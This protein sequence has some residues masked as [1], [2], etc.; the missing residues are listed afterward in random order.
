MAE[1]CLAH[2]GVKGMRWGVRRY[3]NEDGTLTPAGKRRYDKV[4]KKHGK[5]YTAKQVSNL[6]KVR[7]SNFAAAAVGSIM[8]GTGA[9][10]RVT[11]GRS[12]ANDVLRAVGGGMT[13]GGLAGG[14]VQQGRLRAD[15]ILRSGLREEKRDG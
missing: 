13:I 3:E 7:N 1:H 15:N 2:H 4:K 10:F 11:K 9:Y 8:L 5:V 14:I 6:K 12:A